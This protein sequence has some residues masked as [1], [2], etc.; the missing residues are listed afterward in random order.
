MLNSQ[1]YKQGAD[2][3]MNIKNSNHASYCAHCG[4]IEPEYEPDEHGTPLVFVHKDDCNTMINAE[5]HD[6]FN[7]LANTMN[8]MN[9]NDCLTKRAEYSVT[10]AMKPFADKYLIESSFSYKWLN[11]NMTLK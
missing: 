10:K 2:N 8:H 1:S 9:M 7:A 5:A 4:Y 6:M 11:E 3:K